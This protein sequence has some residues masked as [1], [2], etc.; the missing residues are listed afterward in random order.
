MISWG[1]RIILVCVMSLSLGSFVGC[2]TKRPVSQR[3]PMPALA[4]TSYGTGDALGWQTFGKQKRGE[5]LPPLAVVE[6][7]P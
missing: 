6:V 2:S 5:S 3:I 7:E 1:S 4:L